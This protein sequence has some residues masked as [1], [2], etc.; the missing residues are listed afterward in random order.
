MVDAAAPRVYE[1]FDKVAAGVV[2]SLGD[3]TRRAILIAVKESTEPLAASDV[4]EMF[5]IHRTVARHHLNLLAGEGFI[6]TSTAAKPRTVGRPAKRYQAGTREIHLDYPPRNLSLLIELLTHL[7][8]TVGPTD[9]AE[10]AYR[11]GQD[12]GKELAA[13][14]GDS[15]TGGLDGAITT[16]ADT[17]R[18]IGFAARAETH[19]GQLLTSHCPFGAYALDHP[20]VVCSFD[21]GIVAGLM[22]TIHCQSQVEIDPHKNLE[23]V[24]VTSISPH[25]QIAIQ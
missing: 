6:T 2:K 13:E 14:L 12:Y 23:E 15:I 3:A 11:F 1:E 22:G 20:E 9:K 18:G 21:R 19:A 7:V 5:G 16:V 8:E 17:M 4:A 10:V 24:C 25:P